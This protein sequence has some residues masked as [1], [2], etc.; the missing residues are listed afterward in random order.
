[1][2]LQ[3][4][5][6]SLNMRG[7]D[8]DLLQQ[9]LRALHFDVPPDETFFGRATRKAVVA[10]QQRERLEPTGIVDQPTAAA[11]NRLLDQ[12]RESGAVRGIVA[13]ESGEPVAGA[14]IEALDLGLSARTDAEG[15][16]Q[17]GP[18][19]PGR[20]LIRASAADHA[21]QQAEVLVQ[22][23]QS[24][25]R[26]FSLK[27]SVTEE[28]IVRG[29]VSH[30]D[31]RPLVNGV[32]RAFDRDLRREEPLGET[33]PDAAGRYEIHYGKDRFARAEKEGADLVVRAFGADRRELA[34]S[35]VLFNAP[36]TAEVD[37]T[38]PAGTW[39]L[40]SLFE[41]LGLAVSPLLGEVALEELD[42]DTEH[43]DL[44]FLAGETGF[45]RALLARFALSYRLPGDGLQPEFWFAVLGGGTFQLSETQ[46]LSAQLPSLLQFASQL[47]SGAVQKSLASA[48]N[49]REIAEELRERVPAWME[50]F[51][52]FVASR[53]IGDSRRPTFVQAALEHAGIG[54]GEKQEQFARLFGEYRGLTPEMLKRLGETRRFTA[55]EVAELQTSFRLAEVTQGDFST[56]KAIK[57]VFEV[58]R[59][60]QIRALAGASE[61][62]WIDL[63]KSRHAAGEITL[64]L[65]TGNVSRR[66][67]FP[68]AEI[69]GRTLARR[70]R[71]AFPTAAFAGDLGRAIQN[72]GV[73]GLAHAGAI[74]RFLDQHQEFDLLSTSID[75]YLDGPDRP[76]LGDGADSPDFWLELK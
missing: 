76:T 12:L 21:A 7:A 46:S 71:E 68:A 11:I 4:R 59:P 2:D 65:P 53:V 61:G 25:E 58:R 75:Q 54:P 6:L 16:Y 10:I 43:Q 3:D 5:N 20:V 50:A 69:Y 13:A 64:P 28:R 48:F 37:L 14:V 55:R 52:R 29:R 47:D 33:T 60:E 1:M 56:V 67:N 15:R 26:N 45:T 72:G 30:Q 34:V 31:G 17:L 24:V 9:E 41:T 36:M 22:A 23:G 38:V 35:P 42:E 8:V 18:I 51:Q 39:E 73:K 27:R 63:V 74:S 62:D 70:F 19:A 57:E 66:V 44:S 40:P 32:V 49:R